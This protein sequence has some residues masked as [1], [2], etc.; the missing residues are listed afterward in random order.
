T[1]PARSAAPSPDLGTR[2]P[3]NPSAWPPGTALAP[4][5]AGYP[6]CIVPHDT[7]CEAARG[8]RQG[9]RGRLPCDLRIPLPDE[10]DRAIS[11][12]VFNERRLSPDHPTRSGSTRG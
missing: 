2:P 12:A 4:S 5:A 9:F 7:V 6:A 11:T 1:D 8:Q 10:K 3:G